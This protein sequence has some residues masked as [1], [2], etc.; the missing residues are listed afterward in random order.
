MKHL[1]KSK[2]WWG[3]VEGTERLAADANEQTTSDYQ[4][5]CERALACIVLHMERCQLYLITDCE[6]PK[7]AWDRL[8]AHFD[9]QTTANKIYLKK[10]F[11]HLQ[12]KEGSKLDD[13]FKIMKELVDQLAAIEMNIDEEDQVM[14]LLGSLPKKYEGI[15]TALET[16]D[17]LNLI[18]V[19]QAL[20]NA[21]QKN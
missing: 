10:K 8:K 9:R 11:Y 15:V 17:E 21:E 1:L 13:H 18:M 2:G 12:M 3:I 7:E 5:R 16:Q 4:R 6:E 19:Q 20:V 14:T